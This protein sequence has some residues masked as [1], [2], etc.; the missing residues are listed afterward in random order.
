M[1]IGRELIPRAMQAF[2][3]FY[4]GAFGCEEGMSICRSVDRTHRIDTILC[5]AKTEGQCG[6][7]CLSKPYGWLLLKDPG[8]V[9]GVNT[10]HWMD[11]YLTTLVDLERI[12]NR[13]VPMPGLENA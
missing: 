1:Y 6:S 8:L 2:V 12:I 5:L 3:I 9:Q 13:P 4:N 7:N 11:P 10:D